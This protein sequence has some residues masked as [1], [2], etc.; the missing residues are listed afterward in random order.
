LLLL[1]DQLVDLFGQ[2]KILLRDPPLGM[3]PQ[4]QCDATVID[5]DVGVVISSLGDKRHLDRE[6]DSLGKRREGQLTEQR[7]IT[8]IPAGDL[9]QSG[10]RLTFGYGSHLLP[11]CVCTQQSSLN[12]VR[13]GPFHTK[14]DT[15]RLSACSPTPR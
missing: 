8:H 12:N 2:G 4:R 1:L 7:F 5:Q 13:L 6:G 14:E 15:E 10:T 11:P 9:R 3:R